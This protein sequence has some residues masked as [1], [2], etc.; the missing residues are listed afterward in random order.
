MWQ[1]EILRVTVR[2]SVPIGPFVT[3]RALSPSLDVSVLSHCREPTRLC[4]LTSCVDFLPFRK[5]TQALP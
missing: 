5:T 4:Y 2:G 3:L 1:G